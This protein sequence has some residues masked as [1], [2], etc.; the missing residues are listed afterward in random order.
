MSVKILMEKKLQT[1]FAPVE[2]ELED[3]S[4]RHIGHAGHDG[5]GESH[6]HLTMVADSFAGKNRVECQRMV[7]QVLDEFLQ[8]RVH[9]LSLSLKAP[10]DI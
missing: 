2:M 1:A 6:F 10:S 5:K 4:D 8:D 9:A 7:Y 3:Q